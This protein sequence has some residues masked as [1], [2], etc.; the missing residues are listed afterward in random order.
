M[1]QIGRPTPIRLVLPLV[2]LVS[3][4]GSSAPTRTTAEPPRP[5]ARPDAESS[6]PADSTGTAESNDDALARTVD[7]APLAA[8]CDAMSEM[9]AGAGASAFHEAEFEDAMAMAHEAF[10]AFGFAAVDLA[11]DLAT[12][13][14]RGEVDGMVAVY[15]QLDDLSAEVCDFP[16]GGA[17]VA[18]P[19]SVAVVAFCEVDAALGLGD[20]SDD[21]CEPRTYP[22]ELPCFE[23]TGFHWN[24]VATGAGFPWEMVDCESGVPVAWDHSAAEWVAA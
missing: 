9:L 8:G 3:A 24:D 10:S 4:C 21:S 20:G 6:A 7:T 2:L 22:T 15:Q 17:Y 14:D 18:I 16:A 19:G 13:V 23:A 12:A 1:L 11:L 5:L